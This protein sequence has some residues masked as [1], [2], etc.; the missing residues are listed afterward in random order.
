MKYKLCIVMGLLLLAA[1]APAQPKGRGGAVRK[2]NAEEPAADPRMAQML[3]AVQQVVFIDSMVADA[4]GYMGLIP[5]S[6]GC[7]RLS[8]QGGLSSFVSEMGDRRFATVVSGGDTTIACSDLI[9]GRWTEPLPIGGI[10]DEA[11]ANPFLMPDGITLYYAQKGERSIGGYDIF[12]TRYDGERGTF[13]KP[14][15]VGMPF[16]SEGN[17]LFYAVDEWNELGYFVT[18][19][20][21]PEGKVCIYVFIPSESRRVY[22]AE[23]Y[24]AGQLRRLAA[25]GSIAE[26]WPADGKGLQEASARLEAA[27]ARGR[28]ERRVV[29]GVQASRLDTLRRRAASLEAALALA[30]RRYAAASA[31]ERLKLR[32]GIVSSEEELEAL[33]IEIRNKEKQIPSSE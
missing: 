29:A 26:T 6:G 22:P 8:Q 15:N 30:R 12:V 7:G 5:L 19:R 33:L 27:R 25:I 17:D 32:G 3:S 31:D 9:G 16:A 21:Q 2:Q 23:A 18:D 14:E 11:A 20:R 28:A 13:L 4:D 24:D 10:G 1:A